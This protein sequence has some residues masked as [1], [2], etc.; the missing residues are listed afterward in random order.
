MIVIV[1]FF[2]RS[3]LIPGPSM[4]R[5]GFHSSFL[6]HIWRKFD[7]K[8]DA[9]DFCL[10]LLECV[11]NFVWEHIVHD[12]L[13]Q[14]NTDVYILYHILLHACFL[15]TVFLIKSFTFSLVYF[16]HSANLSKAAWG[17]LEKNNTQV[18]VRSYELGVLYL[19]SAFVSIKH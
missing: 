7:C 12:L 19:P 8:R 16:I 17:A 15:W 10:Q 9:G 3:N 13:K 5:D 6:S 18:M 4:P 11:N 2:T 1:R 14:N